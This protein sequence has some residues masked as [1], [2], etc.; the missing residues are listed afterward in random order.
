[1]CL[2]AAVAAGC[3][4]DKSPA[5]FDPCA[6]AAATADCLTPRFPPA[7]YIAEAERYF[8][9]IDVDAPRDSIPAYA[10]D[11]VRWEWPPWLILTGLG[12]DVLVYG[13]LWLTR[14]SPSAV[15]ER[16]CRFFALQPF[17]RCRVVFR[18][19]GG[20]CPIYEEFAFNDAGETTFIEAWSDRRGYLPT[21]DPADPWAEGAGVRRLSTKIPGLGTPAGRFALDSPAMRA[22]A[23]AD[24]DVADFVRRAR[25]FETSWLQELARAGG[26][27][28]E[29]VYAE[30][31]GWRN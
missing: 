6:T 21:D 7:Y 10:A 12:R 5:A 1:M 24:A 19:E 17:A 26:T 31:C 27:A 29:D 23:A 22:A 8:D 13:D 30:G 9:T 3:G 16:D 28:E 20:T 2:A 15:P 11:V 18:Y 14:L 4:G 25:N